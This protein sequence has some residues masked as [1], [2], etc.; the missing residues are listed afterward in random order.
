MK[1]NNVSYN[2]VNKKSSKKKM[3][4]SSNSTFVPKEKNIDNSFRCNSSLFTYIVNCIAFILVGFNVNNGNS[5]F[6]TLLI[7]SLGLLISEVQVTS[8]TIAQQVFH[9][10]IVI[11]ASFDMFISFLGTIGVFTVSGSGY[12]ASVDLSNN[13]IIYVT[14]N[15]SVACF[16]YILCIPMVVFLAIYALIKYIFSY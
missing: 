8:Q 11:Y 9:K 12:S 3:I 6:V 16:F 5:F 15:I 2:K 7:V 10:S 4:H 13:F 14:T 1:Q